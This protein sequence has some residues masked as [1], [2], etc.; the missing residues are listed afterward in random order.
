MFYCSRVSLVRRYSVRELWMC[1]GFE[2]R[3]VCLG[4]LEVLREVC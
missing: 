4:C 3:W 2:G 1:V